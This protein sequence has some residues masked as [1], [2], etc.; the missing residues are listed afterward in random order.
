MRVCEESLWRGLAAARLGGR[1]TDISHADRDVRGRQGTTA[2]SRTTS[3]M[4]SARR[5]TCRPTCPTTAGRAGARLVE[6]MALAIEP[7]ITLGTIETRELDDDWTVITTD[8]SWSA[9]SS[10]RSR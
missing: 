7:M 8:G 4:A 1:L 10:T 6:G 2:S 3:A 5:C 9:H